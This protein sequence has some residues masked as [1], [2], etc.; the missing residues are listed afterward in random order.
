[1]VYTDSFPAYDIL[2]VS[3]LHHARISQRERFATERGYQ[4]HRELLEP[5]QTP[6]APLQRH[7]APALSLYLKEC[8]WRFN[9]RPAS[10]LLETLNAWRKNQTINAI[11][12]APIPINEIIASDN[13]IYREHSFVLGNGLIANFDSPS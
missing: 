8:E 11:W 9:Y 13:M 7:S 10:R 3:E 2:D 6:S 1:V 4:R 12:P 5:S